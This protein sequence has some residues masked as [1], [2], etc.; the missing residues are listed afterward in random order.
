MMVQNIKH[1]TINNYKNKQLKTTPIKNNT[2][3]TIINKLKICSNSL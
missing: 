1:E 3:V 2:K